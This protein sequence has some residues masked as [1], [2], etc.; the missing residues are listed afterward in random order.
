MFCK[1]LY[2]DQ[3]RGQY[4]NAGA[5]HKV[6]LTAALRNLE[7]HSVRQWKLRALNPNL[8]KLHL[9]A[10]DGGGSQEICCFAHGEAWPC[11]GVWAFGLQRG[12]V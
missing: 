7:S 9:N 8:P 3:G 10:S 2:R 11:A 12:R 6:S 4:Q 5:A 1:G